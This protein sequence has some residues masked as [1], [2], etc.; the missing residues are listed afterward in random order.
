MIE[1]GT[2]QDEMVTYVHKD[3]YRNST[4]RATAPLTPKLEKWGDLSSASE[5]EDILR[6]FGSLLKT[7]VDKNPGVDLP[8][9]FQEC[10]PMLYNRIDKFCTSHNWDLQLI[11]GTKLRLQGLVTFSE[12]DDGTINSDKL[13][14]SER[15]ALASLY[16]SVASIFVQ[17]QC[18]VAKDST[19]VAVTYVCSLIAQE[20]LLEENKDY[21]KVALK[22]GD[23]GKSVLHNRFY[24]LTKT[25]SSAI[26]LVIAAI[27][28]I[29]TKFAR[30]L[31]KNS[32]SQQV[33]KEITDRAF[34]TLDGMLDNSCRITQVDAV[35]FET[36]IGR[37]GNSTRERV[38][39]KKSHKVVPDILTAKAPLKPQELTKLQSLQSTF[40]RRKTE[41]EKRLKSISQPTLLDRPKICQEVTNEAY[42]KLRGYK[43]I[44]KQRVAEIRGIATEANQGNKP[45]PGH[46]A[47]ARAQV[48]EKAPDIPDSVYNELRW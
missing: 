14:D 12:N 29:L 13:S 33:I 11:Q 44:L 26:K 17:P 22:N 16:A 23:G 41:V 5:D 34:T 4:V 1:D 35:R 10:F 42:Q 9:D 19:E 47:A 43:A 37:K 18:L 15:L 28:K 20:K 3:W 46:W 39:Y 24:C 27:D 7:T 40:N 30:T 31:D 32:L 38:T 6:A 25:G 8:E 21:L 36:K 45:G 2:V 48:L